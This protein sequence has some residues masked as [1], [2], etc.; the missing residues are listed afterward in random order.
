MLLQKWNVMV[1]GA[2]HY[3]CVNLQQ[4]LDTAAQDDPDLFHG[5]DHLVKDIIFWTHNQPTADFASN[6]FWIDEFSISQ[7]ARQVRQTAYPTVFYLSLISFLLAPRPCGLGV[8][9]PMAC[10]CTRS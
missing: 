7:T 9:V 10:G 4:V 6:E 1:D 2:W 5:Q 8:I 3:D